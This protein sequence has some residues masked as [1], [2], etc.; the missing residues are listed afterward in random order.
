M[1]HD[2]SACMTLLS[3][4]LINKYRKE[5]AY[6]F[7]ICDIHIIHIILLVPFFVKNIILFYHLMNTYVFIF[8]IFEILISLLLYFFN[9][10]LF[11]IV[12]KLFA[13]QKVTNN[14]MVII[15]FLNNL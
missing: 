2:L 15:L 11:K 8:V 9:N 3:I 6:L 10:F 14:I 12:L 13:T 1:I 5:L 4:L 7:S